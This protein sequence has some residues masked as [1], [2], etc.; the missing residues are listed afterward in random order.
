[1]GIRQSSNRLS[2]S[3]KPSHSV[4][5]LQAI[6][7]NF[8][9]RD[10]LRHLRGEG[11][12]R[13]RLFEPARNRLRVRTAAE[14]RVHFHGCEALRVKTQVIHGLHGF[15]VERAAPVARGERAGAPMDLLR[16]CSILVEERR[17]GGNR[18]SFQ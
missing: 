8:L 13:S 3:D 15:R 14:G 5:F 16:H 10:C 6:S 4:V 7:Q 2:D 17:S 1:M 11:E 9:V 12:S 18:T